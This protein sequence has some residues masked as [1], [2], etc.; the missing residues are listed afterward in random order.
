MSTSKPP[1]P[2]GTIVL[3]LLAVAMFFCGVYAMFS[4]SITTPAKFGGD[5]RVYGTDT[6]WVGIGWILMGLSLGAKILFR[7]GPVGT[8]V[9]VGLAVV[10]GVF[11]LSVI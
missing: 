5:H 2:G 11:W 8:I 9:A 7:R 4:D 6:I 1:G 3:A 10:G